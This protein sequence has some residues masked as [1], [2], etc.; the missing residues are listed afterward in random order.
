MSDAIELE[1]LVSTRG[2]RSNRRLGVFALLTL[3][4]VELLSRGAISSAE[5]IPLFFNADNCAF[6]RTKLKDKVADKIMSH[7]VQLLDLFDVLPGKEAQQEF[8]R[9]LRIIQALCLE[10]LSRRKLAA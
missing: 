10:L 6:V 8:Q 7:G 9:E 5:A 1:K 3:G 2:D 4:I